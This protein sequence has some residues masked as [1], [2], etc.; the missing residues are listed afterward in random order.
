MK[1]L[2]IM[3]EIEK[4][5]SKES[6]DTL[7]DILNVYRVNEDRMALLQN[8]LTE[9]AKADS[10]TRV[11]MSMQACILMEIIVRGIDATPWIKKDLQVA[12]LRQMPYDS[13]S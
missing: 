12:E 2:T 9:L 1:L 4:G 10:T 3:K 7:R 5:I 6:L 11:N 13:Q 8:E